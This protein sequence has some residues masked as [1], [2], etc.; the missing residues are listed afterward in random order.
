MRCSYL[1]GA[2]NRL[3]RL[4][5]LAGGCDRGLCG[6]SFVDHVHD[7]CHVVEAVFQSES[8]RNVNSVF[9]HAKKSL[10]VDFDSRTEAHSVSLH[11]E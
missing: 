3:C 1:R 10:S 4:E 7:Q 6:G 11:L 5:R 9:S 8:L 2:R